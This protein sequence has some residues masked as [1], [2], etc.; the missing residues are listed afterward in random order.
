MR[1]SNL[2]ILLLLLLS[3][4][5]LHETRSAA[6]L[7]APPTIEQSSQVLE[8]R[9]F[10]V[11]FVQDSA[12]FF[13]MPKHAN[14]SL[15]PEFWL[16]IQPYLFQEYLCANVSLDP[17]NS[18]TKDVGFLTECQYPPAL[19]RPLDEAGMWNLEEVEE[20]AEG[21]ASVRKVR[22]VVNDFGGVSG[23]TFAVTFEVTPPGNDSYRNIANAQGT[24]RSIPIS[25][26]HLKFTIDLTNYTSAALSQ[27]AD[28]EDLF[29]DLTFFYRVTLSHPLLPWDLRS[30]SGN[31]NFIFPVWM[32]LAY[33]FGTSDDA[34]FVRKVT[35]KS[36]EEGLFEGT[37]VQANFSTADPPSA[38]RLFRAEEDVGFEQVSFWYPM[39]T[40]QRLID[41][42]E[43]TTEF[44]FYMTFAG[45]ANISYDPDLSIFFP[46]EDYGEGSDGD[47][48]G[49][50]DGVVDGD[51][52][53]DGNDRDE[54][55]DE[56]EERK[57][58]VGL[59]VGLVGGAAVVVVLVLA[60]WF[61]GKAIKNK[62]QKSQKNSSCVNF[63]EEN[64]QLQQAQ[65]S[66]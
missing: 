2:S 10:Q 31:P 12:Q 16:S 5:S 47:G 55:D 41:Q 20:E 61:G 56:D 43:N 27:Q 18:P 36:L 38:S 64:Q 34:T 25:A 35:V 6:A 48:D 51:G 53:G 11:R 37:I 9:R 1:Y 52:S 59:V 13:A 50:E 26:D 40:T 32:D 8:G 46:G 24:V 58:I 49:N 21:G 42:P 19:E 23:A 3:L 28:E 7:S 63:G 30:L 54:E 33:L 39:T 17:N 14:G 29:F 60:G 62:V 22:Q 66:L 65:H 4:S 57:L 45:G 44:E 15:N